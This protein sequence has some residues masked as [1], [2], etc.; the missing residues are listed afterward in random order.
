MDPLHHDVAM[1]GLYSLIEILPPEA[2]VKATKAQLSFDI[3]QRLKALLEAYDV[4][5]GV[6]APRMEPSEN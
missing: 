2:F 6:R 1:A 5:V 3:Y 4:Q